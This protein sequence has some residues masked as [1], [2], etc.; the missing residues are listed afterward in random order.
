MDKRIEEAVKNKRDGPKSRKEI[1]KKNVEIKN[2]NQ[3]LTG[4]I[5]KVR[6]ETNLR[7]KAEADTKSKDDIIETLKEIID[8]HKISI[9]QAEVSPDFV[10]TLANAVSAWSGSIQGLQIHP[11][12]SKCSTTRPRIR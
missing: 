2:I 8:L 4:N 10:R 12:G 9:Q 7:S 5:K 6:D 11:G 1:N 3:K